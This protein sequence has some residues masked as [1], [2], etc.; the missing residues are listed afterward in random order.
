[1]IFYYVRHG[2]PIYDPDSL[3]EYGQKQASALVKRFSLYGLDE[4][5]ASDSNRAMLTAKPTCDALKKEMTLLPWMNEGL[6]ASRFWVKRKDGSGCWAF[7]DSDTVRLFNTAAI[8]TLGEKW[9]THPDL[10]RQDF[11]AG[12]SAVHKDVDAFLLQLGFEHIRE[13]GTYRV[14]KKNEKR[15]AL[16][17]HQGAGM[18]FLS[19]LLDIPYPMFCTH[20]DMGHSGVTAIHFNE[21]EEYCIPKVLQ[22]SND[23]HLF[24]EGI[25]QGYQNWIDI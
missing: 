18:S 24:Q 2:D 19:S 12:I 3:T 22:L 6:A 20:F 1:M 15:I 8:R 16:F 4:I 17:A 25:L 5:Y 23:S 7:H 13:D 11:G 14:I 21:K 9:H 10:P